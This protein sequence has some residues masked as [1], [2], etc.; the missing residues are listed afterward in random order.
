MVEFDDLEDLRRI[1]VGV[2]GDQGV[3]AVPE[4]DLAE[5]VVLIV[6]L[7]PHDVPVLEER[8]EVHELLGGAHRPFL[9]ASR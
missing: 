8:E 3:E 7:D 5:P 4:E 6:V 2:S 9:L 1:R